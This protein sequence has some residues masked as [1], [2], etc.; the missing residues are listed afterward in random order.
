ML[1]VALLALG[2]CTTQPG[3][4]SGA[5]PSWQVVP[6]TRA[7]LPY[8]PHPTQILDLYLPVGG[9]S[10]GTIVY[11]HGGSF[12]GGWKESIALTNPELLGLTS[13]GWS[14]AS[15]DYRVDRST[16]RIAGQVDDVHRALRWVQSYGAGEGL[17]TSTVVVVGHSAGGTLVML[18]ASDPDQ[19][20][21]ADAW[22][23]ISGVSDIPAWSKLT[24]SAVPTDENLARVSPIATIRNTDSPGYLMH[25]AQDDVVPVTQA[26]T[27][28]RNARSAGVSIVY[29]EI[30]QT[31][32]C[33]PHSATC[34]MDDAAFLSWLT[35]LTVPAW[36]SYR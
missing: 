23:A 32:G 21:P 5:I 18:A 31:P 24:G 36:R 13:L 1:T 30:L 22:V 33:H 34:G 9:R 19:P 7:G 17:D 28:V 10:M 14:V 2:A 25:S 29:D 11:V 4:R 15:V 16:Q 26:R 27:L 8:G 35:A 3:G 20:L 12:V 6:P